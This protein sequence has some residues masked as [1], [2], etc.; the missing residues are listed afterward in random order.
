MTP[1]RGI[2][3]GPCAWCQRE[4]GVGGKWLFNHI[5]QTLVLLHLLA[6]H[7]MLALDYEVGVRESHTY[8]VTD[9]LLW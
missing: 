1:H 6:S 9:V 3:K 8:I 4:V 7:S 2:Y 5:H